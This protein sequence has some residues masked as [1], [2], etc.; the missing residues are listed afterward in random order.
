MSGPSLADQ[1]LLN[2]QVSGR[3]IIPL[4]RPYQ[5]KLEGER[6]LRDLPDPNDV[7]GDV[8]Y[9]FP[10]VSRLHE[11]F[12]IFY[13]IPVLNNIY[14]KPRISFSFVSPTPSSLRKSSALF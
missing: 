12:E 2:D 8:I 13:V 14:R 5:D 7:Q 11:L 9:L 6:D 1:R 10:K 3:S 4:L